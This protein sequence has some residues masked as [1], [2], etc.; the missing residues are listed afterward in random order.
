M[1]FVKYTKRPREVK[2]LE[3]L[4]S[5]QSS[6]NQ[7]VKL[8]FEWPLPAYGGTLLA[9]EHAGAPIHI[10]IQ[11][12]LGRNP[13]AASRDFGLWSLVLQL[14]RSVKFL[15]Y[16]CIAHRD[17]KPDNIMVQAHG[18]LVI[19]DFGVASL[20]DGKDDEGRGFVGTTGWTAPEVQD[21]AT[22]SKKSADV[23]A[24]G[25]VIRSLRRFCSFLHLESYEVR[26]KLECVAEVLA[27][28]VP[29]ERPCLAHFPVDRFS[30]EQDSSGNYM[31]ASHR[32]GLLASEL[33]NFVVLESSDSRNHGLQWHHIDDD[34]ASLLRSQSALKLKI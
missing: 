16:L 12:V 30:A 33:A 17:L 1:V 31:S 23:Y 28:P 29:S 15:H 26:G 8:I 7:F 10:H 32:L 14:L 13:R 4:S 27:R 18:R 9:L 11:F 24:C 25:A 3:Y 2:V 21:T 34:C 5:I 22:Y 6:L 20:A 19:S